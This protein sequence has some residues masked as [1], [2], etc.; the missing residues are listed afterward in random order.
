MVRAKQWVLKN[1]PDFGAPFNFDND[2]PNATFELKSFDISPD[3]LK[4]GEILVETYLLSNDPAQKFWI[5]TVDR[6]YSKGTQ[7]GEN[8]PARGIGKILASKNDN[9]SVGDYVTGRLCWTTAIIIGDP[10]AADVR[11]ICPEEGDELWWYLSVYGSTALTAYFIFYKYLGLSETE[12]HYGKQFLISGAAGAVGTICVQLAVNVFKASKVI[13]IAG[14]SEKINYL[15]SLGKVVV[16]V[17]YKD[18]RFEQNLI[19]AA[20]ENSVD[21]FVDN[22]GGSILDIGVKT[23]KIQG[24]I[25]ACGS[26]SGYNHPEELVF[27]NYVSVITKRLTL[28]GLLVTDCRENFPEAMKKLKKLVKDKS[29]D[30]KHSATLVDAEDDKFIYVPTIWSGLFQGINR[31]K[32]ITV[33]KGM[34]Q[35]RFAKGE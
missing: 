25:I 10:I 23:L 16:G 17:D 3:D 31:G 19:K 14:G 4:K 24:T 15:E 13:A 30:A 20:A 8:I 18:E 28:K 34:D 6:N 33:V 5:A 32:L 11:K 21:Y 26:I 1:T 9:Y 27:K 12:K 2:D 22:V 35:S 7:L 29:I